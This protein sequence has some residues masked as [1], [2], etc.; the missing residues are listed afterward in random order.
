MPKYEGYKTGQHAIAGQPHEVAV[1][2]GA[3]SKQGGGP[4]AGPSVKSKNP[5]RQ[6]RG[7]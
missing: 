5:R 4:V 1:A 7:G 2:G 3:K 6:R